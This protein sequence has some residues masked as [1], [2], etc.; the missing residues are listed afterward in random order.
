[1]ITVK[2]ARDYNQSAIGNNHLSADTI[3][4]RNFLCLWDPM[5]GLQPLP[6]GAKGL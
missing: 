1:M 6:D 5:P 4:C 3:I 2:N